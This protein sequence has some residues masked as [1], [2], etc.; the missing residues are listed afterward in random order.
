VKIKTGFVLEKVG[1]SHLACATGKLA[2]EFSGFV[3]L[4][5]TGA[6]LWEA[7]TNETDEKALVALLVSTYGIDEN[8]A[9]KDCAA[10]LATLRKNGIL[11]E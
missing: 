6:M 1:D 4:N 10:F 5:D 11:D 8:T 2:T 9:A 3:R 7:L